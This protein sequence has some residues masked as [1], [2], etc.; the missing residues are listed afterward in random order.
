MDFTYIVF[1]ILFFFSVW[2]FFHEHWRFTGQQGKGE[3]ITFKSSLPL[4]FPWFDML[5]FRIGYLL[6]IKMTNNVWFRFGEF[7]VSFNELTTAI[8]LKIWPIEKIKPIFWGISPRKRS[9]KEW[10]FWWVT[11]G[12]SVSKPFNV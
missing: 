7:Y 8:G 3:A 9:K 5:W 10:S 1:F 2:V 4:P 11:P 12:I 6:Q